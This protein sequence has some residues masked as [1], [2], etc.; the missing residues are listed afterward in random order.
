MSTTEYQFAKQIGGADVFERY[1]TSGYSVPSVISTVVVIDS[2]TVTILTSRALS[3]PELNELTALVMAYDYTVYGNEFHPRIRNSVT[4]SVDETMAVDYRTIEEAIAFANSIWPEICTINVLAGTYVLSST[5]TLK[6]NQFL[7]ANGASG[8]STVLSMPAPA[9]VG[10]PIVAMSGQCLLRGFLLESNGDAVGI[11]YDG[12]VVGGGVVSE[13]TMDTVRHGIV[14]DGGQSVLSVDTCIIVAANTGIWVKNGGQA[15]IDQSR[16][17]GA[18]VGLL[19]E[20]VSIVPSYMSIIGLHVTDCTTGILVNGATADIRTAT[21]MSCQTG[22][23][24]STSGSPNTSFSNIVFSKNVTWDIN[25]LAP[26]SPHSIVIVQS[27]MIDRNKINNANRI[28]LMWHSLSTVVNQE[29]HIFSGDIHIGDNI[30]PTRMIVG[31]GEGNFND[32][33]VLRNTNLVGGT[34]DDRTPDVYN[35]TPFNIWSASSTGASLY[36]GHV[37]TSF[38][39]LRIQLTAGGSDNGIWEYWNGAWTACTV[40]CIER[41]PPFV[42]HGQNVFNQSSVPLELYVMIGPMPSRQLSSLTGNNLYWVRYR[43]LGTVA[44]MATIQ[45]VMPV[46]DSAITSET[47]YT[48]R[49]GKSRAVK[50]HPFVSRTSWS[51]QQFDAGEENYF[52]TTL[53]TPDDLDTSCHV[54]F[55]F[56]YF[57]TSGNGDIYWTVS[58]QYLGE[59]DAVGVTGDNWILGPHL[60]EVDIT[61]PVILADA[62]V[63]KSKSVVLS[64]VNAKPGKD[65]LAIRLIR[66]G[67]NPLDTLGSE[68][69]LVNCYMNYVSFVDGRNVGQLY[70]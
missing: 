45:R 26:L 56:D 13:I 70:Q 47:G 1:L 42:H 68:A 54:T 67:T 61:D 17:S 5:L 50:L 24:I 44:T 36:I 59:G 53:I 2:A 8:T 6:S 15:I 19:V 48:L 21:V 55:Y 14:C 28:P 64:L 38:S 57:V 40:M 58:Y 22:A 18:L 49:F 66:R 32:F 33:K 62:G 27:C 10:T 12:T 29:K 41:D 52:A 11:A 60:T 20:G 43:S 9:S 51:Y 37:D 31:R 7:V 65:T 25:I 69:M 46:L 16:V 63:L 30:T 23:E 4:V 39:G 34:W 3:T 35:Q